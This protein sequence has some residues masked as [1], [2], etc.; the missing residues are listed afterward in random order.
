MNTK[1]RESDLFTT[2][3]NLNETPKENYFL[4]CFNIVIDELVIFD[5][6]VKKWQILGNI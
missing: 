6:Y 5:S 2:F 4:T 1:Y 3:K